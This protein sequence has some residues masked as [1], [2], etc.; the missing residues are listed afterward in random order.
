MGSSSS[1]VYAYDVWSEP[2]LVNWIW[3]ND[4]TGVQFCY[5]EASLQ[6]FR[7]WLQIKY[8]SLDSLNLAWYR[9]FQNWSEVEPPRFGTILSYSDFMDWQNFTS[10]KLAQDLQFYAQ[11]IRVKDPKRIITSHSASP[12]VENNPLD[13]Y[14]L[15]DDWRV[16]ISSFQNTKV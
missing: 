11:Q 7:Q 1:V 9:S 14:S 12:S 10:M 4:L 13:D 2:T 8:G 6:R 15:P 16:L 5:C 3:F